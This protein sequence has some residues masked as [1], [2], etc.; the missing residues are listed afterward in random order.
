MPQ[1]LCYRNY[2]RVKISLKIC[3]EFN[4]AMSVCLCMG[5]C[6]LV[7]KKIRRLGL[8]LV[9]ITGSC[10]KPDTGPGNKVVLRVQ[11]CL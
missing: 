8:L 6:F 11:L 2:K 4:Y 3:F 9:G 10:Q 1:H 7:P 5:M